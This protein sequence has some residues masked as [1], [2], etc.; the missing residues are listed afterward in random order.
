[1]PAAAN[2]VGALMY[3]TA[4]NLCYS[5]GWAAELVL[6]R[7]ISDDTGALGAALFRYGFVFSLGLTLVPAGLATLVWLGRIALAAP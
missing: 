6:R 3:G 4:A 5:A 7:W 2:V 1:M